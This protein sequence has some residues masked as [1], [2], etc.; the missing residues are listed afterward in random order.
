MAIVLPDVGPRRP[1]ATQEFVERLEHGASRHEPAHC[2]AER[3]LQDAA[4]PSQ[5]PLLG[6]LIGNRNRFVTFLLALAIMAAVGLVGVV[7]YGAADMS[8]ETTLAIALVVLALAVL[9][10]H[11][12]ATGEYSS[13]AETPSLP[14][15]HDTHSP[16]SAAR[17]SCLE[18]TRW[19][20]CGGWSRFFFL[21]VSGGSVS[22]GG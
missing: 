1:V 15:P 5:E 22:G 4:R 7:S 19:I 13:P 3:D 16:S 9:I 2:I 12:G 11:S 17:C 18:N 6:H 20:T 10:A 8:N 21:L 14:I